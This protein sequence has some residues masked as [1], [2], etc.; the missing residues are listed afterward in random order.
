M[1]NLRRGRNQRHDFDEECPN[2]GASFAVVIDRGCSDSYE[3]ECPVCGCSMKL[4]M[5]CYLNQEEEKS[6]AGSYR[7]DWT[8]GVGC[9]R[10]GGRGVE[11]S[12]KA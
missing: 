3:V 2:C 10:D 6:F 5:L 9:F 11:D 12:E 4:C 1:H 7:C 8:E